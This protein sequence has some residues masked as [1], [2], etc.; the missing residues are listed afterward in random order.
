MAMNE[1]FDEFKKYKMHEYN[2]LENN[3]KSTLR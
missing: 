2:N 1:K 3:D